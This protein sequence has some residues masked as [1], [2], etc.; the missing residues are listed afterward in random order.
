MYN[1]TMCFYIC[2]VILH[3]YLHKFISVNLSLFVTET[4]ESGAKTRNC[5]TR[6]G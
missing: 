4:I 3:L 2:S 1:I 5:G 6:E